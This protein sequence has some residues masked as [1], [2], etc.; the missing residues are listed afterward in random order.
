MAVQDATTD[1]RDKDGRGRNRVL[2]QLSRSQW[3][4]LQ[5]HVET[6]SLK[7]G[8]PLGSPNEHGARVVFPL[9][10]IVSLRCEL[11]DGHGS[12]FAMVGNEGMVGISAFTSVEAQPADAVVQCPG[13]ALS[14]RASVVRLMFDADPA[15]RSV[16]LRYM[17]ALL[18]AASQT[19]AC[20][21]HHGIEQQVARVL[22]ASHDRLEGLL[23]PLTHEVI[24]RMLGVRREG[25]TDAANALRRDGLIEYA[26]GRIHLRDLQGLAERACE[27][28]AQIRDEYRRMSGKA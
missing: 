2:T 4:L 22:L 8:K 26:R 18:N 12:E 11:A 16:V 7:R 14:V 27:C 21:R 3:E 19:A 17:Q 25:V 1:E 15:F 20:Y 10:C 23:L 28:H 13:R 9:D 5:P 6:L 24:G